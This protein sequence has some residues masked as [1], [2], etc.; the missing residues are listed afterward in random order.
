MQHNAESGANTLGAHLVVMND[1]TENTNV[2][3]ALMAGGYLAGNAR[4]WLGY[5]RTATGANT[6]YTL[7]GSTGN[8]LPPTS[9]GGPTPGIYQNWD[10][11]EP[12][13]NGYQ[14]APGCFIGCNAY[15]CNN[16]EQCVQMRSNALWNDLA[17]QWC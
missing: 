11:A 2:F 8:F 5:K 13:N 4:V 17:M 16:G 15:E 1:A 7:D 10:V 12:N 6:F 9:A 3:N 14:C